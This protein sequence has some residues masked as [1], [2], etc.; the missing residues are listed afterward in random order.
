[1]GNEPDAGR[2]SGDVEPGDEASAPE[3]PERWPVLFM[4]TIAMAALYVGFRLVQM[5]V[6]FLRWVF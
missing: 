5:A 3:V 1:M 6:A 2:S 4:L